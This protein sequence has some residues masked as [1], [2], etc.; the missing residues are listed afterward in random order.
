MLESSSW[1]EV[2]FLEGLQLKCKALTTWSDAVPSQPHK[3][4][5]VIISIFLK[6]KSKLRKLNNFPKVTNYQIPKARSP[7]L[8]DT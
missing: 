7:G 2:A 4:W 5:L 6:S 8:C 3:I 1:L